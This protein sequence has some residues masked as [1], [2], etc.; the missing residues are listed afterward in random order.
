MFSGRGLLEEVD[1]S[2]V[3]LSPLSPFS[4]RTLTATPRL[5]LGRLALGPSG[6]GIPPLWPKWPK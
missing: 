5:A 2:A 3:E 1:E 6:R 4:A